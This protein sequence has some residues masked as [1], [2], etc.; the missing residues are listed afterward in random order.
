MAL[1][2]LTPPPGID[3]KSTAFEAGESWY[4][5]NNMRFRSGRAES[6]GGWAR[7]GSYSL[8]GVGRA[9]FSSKDYEGNN[10]QW[11][12]TTWKL[13]V[14]AGNAAIDIT[15]IRVTDSRTGLS[16]NVVRAVENPLVPGEGCALVQFTQA[17]HGLAVNDWVN[18]TSVTITGSPV[19]N[20]T[21]AMFEIDLGFQV[22]SI[23]DTDNFII[24]L[25]D[26]DGAAID[27]GGTSFTD[28]FSNL[29]MSAYTYHFRETSGL[30]AAVD[31]QGFGAGLWGGSKS[32]DGKAFGAADPIGLDGSGKLL[33]TDTGHVL[34]NGDEVYFND[35]AGTL[36]NT[37]P[38]DTTRLNGRW[39][40]VSDKTTNNFKIDVE[41]TPTGTPTAGGGSGA[42]YYKAK[43]S[44]L[45]VYDNVLRGF[46]DASPLSLDVGSVR[47]CYIDNY[48][49][50]IIYAN[51]GS[52]LYY[53]DT[54][55][56][57]S[58]G[59][60]I[61]GVTKP[62]VK[63]SDAASFLGNSG[64]PD[65]VD[66][67]LVSKKDGH[68]VAL[69]CDDVG[70]S[71]SLNPLLVRWSDQQNPFDWTPT[72][73]NTS[74]GQVLRVG[75]R[76]MGGVSTK[77][78]VLI[79][80]D[81]A[82]YSMRFKGPPDVF[83]FTLV[84]QGVS[85]V[86]S[87]S[88]AN[89]SNVVYFMGNDGFYVYSGSVTPLPCPVAAYVYDDFNTEQRAKVYSAV[90]SAFSEVSWFYPS[91]DSFEC[92]RY[93]TF[94]YDEKVW[95][96]G[97]YDMTEMDNGLTSTMYKNRTAWRDAV[98]FSQPMATILSSYTLSSALAPI[99]IKTQVYAHD[100]QVIAS[101]PSPYIETGDLS[102]A[103]G[104]RLSLYTE[105]IPDFQIFNNGSYG[106]TITSI[107]QS[108]N[109]PGGTVSSPVS[110]VSEVDSSGVYESNPDGSGFSVRGR[111]RAIRFR[112]ESGQSVRGQF[113]VGDYRLRLQPDGRR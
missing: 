51:S 47:R 60:P 62:A 3:H 44:P 50:D 2:K 34:V 96:Y 57:T 38:Y 8:E 83:Q 66:S 82:V 46:G 15:P 61:S 79:F 23:V 91:S 93:V 36:G 29:S 49:E 77:D 35:L 9:A 28:G 69:G 99:L 27:F 103:E 20:Y 75:S 95:Y 4:D 6:I 39:W 58:G 1:K 22:F 106:A 17:D 98:V 41:V 76:I 37:I 101:T 89:A 56:N 112:V 18:F 10:Y 63:M 55:S 65:V 64:V 11:V 13:Y 107:L 71:G 19:E 16:A 33:V 111:G 53:Y 12:G 108:Q 113:R 84:T 52:T 48:G 105:I 85:V 80:T 70:S 21:S 59:V 73:T 97:K 88:A 30:D 100:S 31:G 110:L 25:T 40:A 7:D 109:Y 72:P 90:D 74:G 67:F 86:S 24:Y 78:E 54:D 43:G 42:T 32:P 92:N 68:C 81:S 102:I 94:N 45:S 14:V 5:S 104:D 26:A 87:T